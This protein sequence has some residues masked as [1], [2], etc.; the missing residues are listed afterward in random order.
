MCVCVCVFSDLETR[1]K[2]VLFAYVGLQLNS[3]AGWIFLLGLKVFTQSLCAHRPAAT[4]DLTS[5]SA[6][7]V[8]WGGVAMASVCASEKKRFI[9][10]GPSF[11]LIKCLLSRHK[12]PERTQTLVAPSLTNQKSVDALQRQRGRSYKLLTYHSVFVGENISLVSAPS[13]LLLV[14]VLGRR[15]K[16]RR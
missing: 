13:D 6:P 1:R 9:F 4:S 8:G 14:S 12:R 7:G 11:H 2:D 15:L 10:P 16:C 5:H 3:A